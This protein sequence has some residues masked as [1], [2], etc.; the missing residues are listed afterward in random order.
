MT[1]ADY[2]AA[3]DRS[4]VTIDKTY[5]RSPD[6]WPLPARSYLI[7]TILR[8]FPIPKLALHQV[9]DLRTRRT[10]KKVVDGQQRSA[11]IRDFYA[12]A[13][14]LARNLEMADAKG[15]I[16]SELPTD[17]QEIF[18][19]Y[20]LT[21]DQFE[22]ASEED[23]REYFRRINSFTAPLNAE[24]QRHARFQGPMKWFINHLAR[25]DGDTFVQ[26]GVLTKR[27]VIRMA[28][29]KLLAEIVH[30]LLNGVTTTS[31]NTLNSMYLKFDRGDE[32]PGA[33]KMDGAVAEALDEI[34][35]LT[36]VHTTALMKMNVFYSLVLA[37]ILVK[38]KW[39]TLN[40]LVELPRSKKL[41]KNAESNLLA[42]AAALEEP[43]AYPEYEEFTEAAAEKTNVKD[44]RETRVAWLAAALADPNF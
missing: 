11:A 33:A 5:Q 31:K 32:V 9:T 12:D 1:I 10:I 6:V 44:Q 38:T 16:Y 20:P 41:H 24:E 17:L 21:F 35:G 3:F 25:R 36:E 37:V 23:V 4:E 43:E 2:C 30:A 15:S 7:E 19:A 13:L 22:A 26:L 14:R 42:L 34:R 39:P 29:A 28:D 40:D 8:E 27:S 18:L